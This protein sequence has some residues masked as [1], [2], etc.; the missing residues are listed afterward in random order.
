MVVYT[1][2]LI[3]FVVFLLTKGITNES[4]QALLDPFSLSTLSKVSK[5]W[6]VDV[7]NTRLIPM[8]GIILYNKIFWITV[9]LIALVLGYLKFQMIVVT[10]KISFNKNKQTV[11]H[12]TDRSH[13]ILPMVM[14]VYY[15]RAQFVQLLLNACFTANPS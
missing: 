15:I 13:K 12:S 9:A 1:Q 11:P 8:F 3:L 14:P 7:R 2:G 6:T 10:D 4:L 5:D